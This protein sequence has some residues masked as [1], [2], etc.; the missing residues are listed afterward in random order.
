MLC[1]TDTH[2]LL[3]RHAC[4]IL[5]TRTLSTRMPY[6]TDTH[7]LLYRHAC[8]VLPTRMLSRIP[9]S[10]KLN[11]LS[12]TSQHSLGALPTNF[13]LA[14]VERVCV[15]WACVSVEQSIRVSVE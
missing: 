7:A 8:P 13:L 10:S 11:K 1:S 12:A 6:S 9:L 5:L 2:A 15:L 4:P 3:Y 14:S